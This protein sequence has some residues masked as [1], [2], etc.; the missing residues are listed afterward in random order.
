MGFVSLTALV[1]RAEG[2]EPLQPGRSLQTSPATFLSRAWAPGELAMLGYQP[3]SSAGHGH[4]S[5]SKRM[6]LVRQVQTL[7][8]TAA[9]PHPPQTLGASGVW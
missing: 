1:G 2:A 9:F 4:G 8:E 7:A 6:L 3:A 5:Q